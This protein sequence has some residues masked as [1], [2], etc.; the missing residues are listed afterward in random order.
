MIFPDQ[1][2]M[3]H[4]SEALWRIGGG[5]SVM[6]GSGFSRNA[7]PRR[8]DPP[9]MPTL[10]EMARELH[11]MLHPCVGNPTDCPPPERVP[12]LAEEYQAAFGPIGLHE[13]L[14][15]MVP[16]RDYVPGPFHERLLRMPWCDTFTTN[17][18]TLL[19]RARAVPAYA[20]VRAPSDLPSSTRP[21]IVKLHGS[22]PNPPLILTEEAYRTYRRTYAPFVNTVQQAMME[23]VV[24]LLGFSG[25]DAASAQRR[26]H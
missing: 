2:Y 1:P 15:R 3:N 10:K 18:D 26:S 5:A 23:T 20:A 8:P 17:W 22:L 12:R 7:R 21:R 4:V 19:E 14:R 11:R 24:L 13:A 6:V 16:D 9:P 25:D